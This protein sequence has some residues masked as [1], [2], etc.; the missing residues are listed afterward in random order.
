MFK[1]GGVAVFVMALFIALLSVIRLVVGESGDED[2]KKWRN[3]LLWSLAGL[4]LISIAY[5][6]VEIFDIDS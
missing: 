6:I 5:Y 3:T 4:F 1:S 2:F